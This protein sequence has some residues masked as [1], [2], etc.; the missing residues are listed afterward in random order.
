MTSRRLASLAFVFVGV[1]LVAAASTPGTPRLHPIGARWFSKKSPFNTPIPLGAR[2]DSRS[3]TMISNLIAETKPSGWPISV[4]RWTVPVYYGDSSTPRQNVALT[5]YWAP[6]RVLHDV[7]VPA[8][9]QADPSSDGHMAIIDRDTACFYEFYRA[10]HAPDGKLSAGW[11]NR[12]SVT[13]KGIQPGAWST[14][15]SGF[16]NFAG[17][18]RPED[19]RA[20]VI[21]HAL[22][23]STMYSLKGPHVAPATSSGG[24]PLPPPEGAKAIPYG[25]RLQLDPA[26]DLRTLDLA[27]WQKVVARAL[28]VYGMYLADTGGFS[29]GAVNPMGYEKN[30]YTPFWGDSD[31]AYL[32]ASLVSHLRVLKLGGLKKAHGF[33]LKK[34]RC[35]L[36]R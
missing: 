9:A 31:Y 25:A 4:K 13:G 10:V 34:S 5:S 12:G 3:S 28:Q 23:F 29:V 7:P 14:R 8:N 24:A 1:A 2:I 35:G 20:G 22:V 11:A 36:E 26:L 17:L 15:D 30:P 27:P 19:L 6:A 16:V 32:P 21:R 18:I 33:L